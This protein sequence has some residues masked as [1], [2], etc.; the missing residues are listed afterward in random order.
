MKNG[1]LNS[2]SPFAFCGALVEVND[3]RVKGVARIDLHVRRTIQSLIWAD[4]AKTHAAGERPSLFNYEPNDAGLA[5][6]HDRQCDKATD[7]RE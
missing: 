7:R 2:T 1:A 4:I 5:R 3:Y 6:L